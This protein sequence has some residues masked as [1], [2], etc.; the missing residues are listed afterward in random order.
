MERI[1]N[2]ILASFRDFAIKHEYKTTPI[3]TAYIDVDPTDPANIRETPAWSIQL[4]NEIK[5]LEAD[6]DPKLM[7]RRSFQER[8]KNVE[9]VI[10]AQ[11]ADRKP[12]GRSVM[13]LSDLD[14]YV[15]VYLPVKMATNLYYGF[16]QIKHL[17]FALD[18]YKPYEVVLF[19]GSET[20]V[21]EVFLSRTSSD[22]TVETGHDGARKLSRKSMEAGHDR[23]TPEFERRFVHEIASDI[24]RRYRGDLHF[25]RLV[26]GGNLKL[27]HAVKN[28][29]HPAVGEIVVAI[30]PMDFKLHEREIAEIVQRIAADFE[31]AH[32]L[33]VVEELMNVHGSGGPAV[34]ERQGVETA[35]SRGQV[36]RLILA[37]PIEADEF[38]ALIVDVIVSGADIE[39]VYGTAADRLR[40]YGGIGATLYYS[41][42]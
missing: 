32:D 9:E 36:K 5:E 39:F 35:V 13:L 23:R 19:S 20:R 34:I 16:P 14:D 6:L 22:L 40:E 41:T 17:L 27:A 3:L 26:F 30:E 4:K 11:L 29:L 7:K 15:A 1:V 12:S 28:A 8:W 10:R 18:Q 42:R 2:R 33:A 25:E 37:Y 31:A 21:V 24:N 38:D